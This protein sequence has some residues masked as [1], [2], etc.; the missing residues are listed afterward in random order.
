MRAR[1]LTFEGIPLNEYRFMEVFLGF[2]M[3]LPIFLYGLLV[4]WTI[5][6]D[7]DD[8]GRVPSNALVFGWHQEAFIYNCTPRQARAM[9]DKMGGW[10]AFHGLLSYMG[11][12]FCWWMRYPC[13]RYDRSRSKSAF[14]QTVA[15]LKENR[16]GLFFIRTDAGG[17]YGK[18]RPS[19]ARLAVLTDRPLVAFRQRPSHYVRLGGHYFPLPFARVSTCFS[20]ALPAQQFVDLGKEEAQR[21][22]QALIDH[23]M[24]TD[25]HSR[26]RVS[27]SSSALPPL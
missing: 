16:E 5:Q 15:H 3:G 4:G 2:W 18:V 26:G 14:D 17:P 25:H 24:P 8:I 9:A 10:L 7:S 1:K 19:M 21:R 20:H 6:E 11:S 23:T 12:L 13:F 27:Q 22:L